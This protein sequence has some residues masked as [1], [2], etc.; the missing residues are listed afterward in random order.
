MRIAAIL[1]LLALAA[2]SSKADEIFGD[3]AASV[4][5]PDKVVAFKIANPRPMSA[6]ILAWPN[7]GASV[8]LDPAVAAELS[9]LLVDEKSYRDATPGA[10]GHIDPAYRLVF[11]RAN[12]PT[13]EFLICLGSSEILGA[14]AQ[15]R[16]DHAA[17]K[18]AALLKR[19]FPD[20]PD[21]KN[22]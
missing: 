2:C 13:A 10:G 1:P 17:G 11:T 8:V 6:R 15:A 4:R 12:S 3:A 5:S 21:L 18:V 9:A 16:F 20:D 19:V 14:A 7:A 22:R